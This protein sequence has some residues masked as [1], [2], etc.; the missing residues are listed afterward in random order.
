LKIPYDVRNQHIYIPGKTRHGKSTLLGEMALQDIE[1]K[2]IGAGVCVIDPKGDLVSKMLHWIPESRKDDCIYIDPE[3]PIPIDFW[4]A[5]SPRE[6]ETLAD[7]LKHLITKGVSTDS[8]PLMESII[9]DV[10]QTLFEAKKNGFTPTF[11]DIHDFLALPSCRQRVM[12]CI[13][14]ERWKERW[15]DGNFPNAKDRQPT[16]TRMNRY[17][18]SEY[19]RTILGCPK[20]LLNIARVMDERKIL[21]VNLGGI[22]EP[23]RIFAT[24][25]VSKIY[26]AAKRRAKLP[27]AERIP[28]HLYVDEFEFFQ[29]QDFTNILSFAGG[30]GLRL[31]L[32]NQ[33]L[34]QLDSTIKASIK[35]NVDSFIIFKLSPEDAREFRYLSDG[36][37]RD[38][39]GEPVALDLAQIHKH[40]AFYAI[41]GQTKVYAPTKPPRGHPPVSCAPYIRNRTLRDY[42]CPSGQTAAIPLNSEHGKYPLQTTHGAVLPDEEQA[43]SPSGLGGSLRAQEPG[44]RGSTPKTGTQPKRYPDRKPD[45]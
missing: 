33:F 11:L 23:S 17:V 34:S 14:S 9:S 1:Q 41:S 30:Y 2:P 20:P 8:M 42:R 45:P 10:I 22:D 3:N 37:Y 35:G 7:E 29:T 27:E 31:T 6:E 4:D 16:V 44:P 24:I 25:L 12:G 39:R 28:F 19:L 26:Q 32:A 43:R 36:Y 21:L 13:E 15:S 18:N 5:A 40:W 38:D